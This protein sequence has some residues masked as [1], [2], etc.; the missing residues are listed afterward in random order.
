MQKHYIRGKRFS[1]ETINDIVKN[2][3]LKT[4]KNKDF[5][6]KFLG[7]VSM[8]MPQNMILKILKKIKTNPLL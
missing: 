5:D 6:T 4:P 2:I 8:Y 1:P 3:I 7:K